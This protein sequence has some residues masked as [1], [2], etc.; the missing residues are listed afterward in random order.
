MGVIIDIEAAAKARRFV[1]NHEQLCKLSFIGQTK[2][3]KCIIEPYDMIQAQYWYAAI[4]DQDALLQKLPWKACIVVG[5]YE[6]GSKPDAVGAP[7][8][9]DFCSDVI[10]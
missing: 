2:Y 4:F 7:A 8:H 9:C 5:G 10:R 1:L 3:G 6:H